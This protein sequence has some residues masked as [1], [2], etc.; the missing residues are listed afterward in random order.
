MSNVSN[1]KKLYEVVVTIPVYVYAESHDK[2]NDSARSLSAL[3]AGL[4]AAT[5]QATEVASPEDV[6][7]EQRHDRPYGSE[8]RTIGEIMYWQSKSS[9]TS[10]TPSK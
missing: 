9:T 4:G 3:Q 10:T 1:V 5:T 7:Q 6:P 8:K 2:A